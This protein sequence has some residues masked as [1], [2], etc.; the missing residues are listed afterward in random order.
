MQRSQFLR[1]D[2]PPPP[3]PEKV[4]SSLPTSPNPST[5]SRPSLDDFAALDLTPEELAAL[6]QELL[7]GETFDSALDDAPANYSSTTQH[8]VQPLRVTKADREEIDPVTGE[9]IKY[10]RALPDRPLASD[11]PRDDLAG[12]EDVSESELEMLARELEAEER[13]SKGIEEDAPP[14]PEKDDG[15]E[16]SVQEPMF[17]HRKEPEVVRDEEPA[18]VFEETASVDERTEDSAP[19]Q[20][21]HDDKVAREVEP[22][23]ET[24]EEEKDEPT[25]EDPA[26]DTTPKSDAALAKAT[27]I[28]G[29]GGASLSAPIEQVE[30]LSL[31]PAEVKELKTDLA[32]TTLALE[33]E[34]PSAFEEKVIREAKAAAAA[35]PKGEDEKIVME[36]RSSRREVDQLKAGLR[37]GKKLEG[38]SEVPDLGV[39]AVEERVANAIR[40]GEL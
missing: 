24:G 26:A 14:V 28:P 18:L 2:S 36:G 38:E 31:S 6:E 9:R 32:S 1:L 34:Q 33:V 20:A 11:A 39:A 40:D 35:A 13:A 37:E 19:K 25:R 23:V 16:S 4:P 15:E 17:G 5:S 12:L 29:M 21:Q 30:K 8:S 27:S 10:V 3:P 22:S 7:N